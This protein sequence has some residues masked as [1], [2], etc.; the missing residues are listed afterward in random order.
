MVL[1]TVIALEFVTKKKKK[2]ISYV[3]ISNILVFDWICINLITACG[4]IFDQKK[5]KQQQHHISIVNKY[6]N[7]TCNEN[8]RNSLFCFEKPALYSHLLLLLLLSFY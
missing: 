8:V 1:K 6:T 3:F 2:T 7:G 4:F 5:Q